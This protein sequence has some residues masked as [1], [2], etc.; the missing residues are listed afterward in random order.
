MS[1]GS[2]WFTVRQ[3]RRASDK[4]GKQ[5]ILFQ[6]QTELIFTFPWHV[7]DHITIYSC[8]SSD[9]NL[10]FAVLGW[11][12]DWDQHTESDGWH[13]LCHTLRQNS[14][15]PGRVLWQAVQRYELWHNLLFF[16][17]I[18]SLQSLRQTVG[19]KFWK[20]APRV[21]PRSHVHIQR[22]SIYFSTPFPWLLFFIPV[23]SLEIYWLHF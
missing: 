9:T 14:R 22:R 17:F 5:F 20:L 11:R 13:L 2:I 1:D 15:V 7:I 19:G 18:A 23:C 8:L 10:R 21:G 3:L 6:W 4:S 16:H 12:G